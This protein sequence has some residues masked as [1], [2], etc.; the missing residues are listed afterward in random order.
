MACP[1]DNIHYLFPFLLARS[2]DYTICIAHVTQ[3]LKRHCPLV[4]QAPAQPVIYR[5]ATQDAC[6]N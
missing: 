4:P 5:T 2:T 3:Q 1:N 6:F